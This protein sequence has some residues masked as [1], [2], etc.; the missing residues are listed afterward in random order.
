MDHNT[1]MYGLLD[2]L[3]K[4]Q[5]K[6]FKEQLT[7]LTLDGFD[8]I[9][10]GHLEKADVTDTVRLMTQRYGRSR[11]MEKTKHILN[12]LG[13]RNST[14]QQIGQ[15]SEDSSTGSTNQTVRYVPCPVSGVSECEIGYHNQSGCESRLTMFTTRILEN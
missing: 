5:F 8:P 13:H 11:C 7:Q 2:Q 6:R 10:W 9:P 14:Q 15:T 4:S 12:A 3:S 1:Q